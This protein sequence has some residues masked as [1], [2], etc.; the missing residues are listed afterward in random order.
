MHGAGLMPPI[1]TA[2]GVFVPEDEADE[3]TG[4]LQDARRA[5]ESEDAGNA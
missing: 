1:T 4:V 2:S 3:S 5:L